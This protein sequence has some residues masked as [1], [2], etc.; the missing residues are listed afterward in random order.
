[1]RFGRAILMVSLFCTLSMPQL[2]AQKIST[3]R[4]EMATAIKE[5]LTLGIEVQ[6]NKLTE[7]DGFYKNPYIKI[8]LPQ[9]IADAEIASNK[10]HTKLLDHGVE[11][12]N[13]AAEK[14]VGQAIPIFKQTIAD[15]EFKNARMVLL[16]TDEAATTHFRNQSSESLFG[17]FRPLVFESIKSVGADRIWQQ[18]LSEIPVAANTTPDINDY[19][20]AKA[21]DGVFKMVAVE[22]KKVRNSPMS[23]TTPL[24]RQVFK[25]QD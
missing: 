6:V 16:S 12:L 2:S 19:V 1:M 17:K 21:L 22:E 9:A 10:K 7:I 11:L 24:V 3:T 5:V 25:I 18:I 23:R 15:L 20:T 4:V 8:L 14:A 13:R